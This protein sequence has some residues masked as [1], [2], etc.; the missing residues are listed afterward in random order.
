MAPWPGV[1]PH[2][3]STAAQI[4]GG[5]RPLLPFRPSHTPGTPGIPP[6]EWAER[7]S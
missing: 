5:G 6:E 1:D 2:A 7:P 3:P 4:G